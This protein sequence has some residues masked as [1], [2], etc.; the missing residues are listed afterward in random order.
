VE[1]P[2][3]FGEAEKKDKDRDAGV[4]KKEIETA[5]R[6]IPSVGDKGRSW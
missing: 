6:K 1:R 3:K 5:S 4:E 2:V